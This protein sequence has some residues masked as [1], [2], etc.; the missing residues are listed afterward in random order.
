MINCKDCMFSKHISAQGTCLCTVHEQVTLPPYID[1][2]A[3]RINIV[4]TLDSCGLAR[5][6][7]L[8]QFIL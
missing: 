1:K 4:N 7:M 5:A 8:P 2:E 3:H 6:K